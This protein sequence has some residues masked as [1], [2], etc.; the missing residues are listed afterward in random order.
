MTRCD[1]PDD[2]P[3]ALDSCVAVPGEC[4]F[5]EFCSWWEK[6]SKDE[7]SP[8][9]NAGL[10][11]IIL[12]RIARDKVRGAHGSAPLPHFWTLAKAIRRTEPLALTLECTA[13]HGQDAH[14]G[15]ASRKQ[16]WLTWPS[17]TF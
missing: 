7:A 13:A 3:Q 17:D 6:A 14:T 1:T 4:H 11:L 16:G 10:K 12:G 15:N 9:S 2:L 5:A 8:A